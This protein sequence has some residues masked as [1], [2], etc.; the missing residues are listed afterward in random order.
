M[1]RNTE[2]GRLILAD[3][4]LF[5]QTTRLFEQELWPAI[6]KAFADALESWAT[7]KEWTCC[8]KDDE[9]TE[10]WLAPPQWCFTKTT[11]KG[12]RT[13]VDADP[14]F[15]FAY[16]GETD[17]YPLADL[18]DVGST[19]IALWFFIDNHKFEKLGIAN[20]KIWNSLLNAVTEE[21]IP[22]LQ[23]C[24]FEPCFIENESRFYIPVV[25]DAGAIADAWAN[26]DY[27][28]LFEPLTSALN[29]LEKSVKIFDEMMN[30]INKKAAASLIK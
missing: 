29:N 12:K 13:S 6:Q 2:A 20:R 28:K 21:Y 27:R 30:E 15:S 14:R 1:N 9:I 18:C 17:S 11:P 8:V 24:C 4:K 3:L 16:I 19:Q 10:F 26:N 7:D 5:D 22:R 23:K 25:L